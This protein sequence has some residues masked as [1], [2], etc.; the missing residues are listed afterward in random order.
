MMCCLVGGMKG[1]FSC[2]NFNDLPAD[3]LFIIMIY[4]GLVVV[5]RSTDADIPHNKNIRKVTR[6]ETLQ[7]ASFCSL[8]I[9]MM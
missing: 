8:L 5:Y 4:S 3:V 7:F 2:N 6:K 1:T 9:L